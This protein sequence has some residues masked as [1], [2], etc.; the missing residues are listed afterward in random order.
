MKSNTLLLFFCL[1]LSSLTL[2]EEPLT[3]IA[4]DAF[5]RQIAPLLK[6][7]CFGC[8]GAEAQEGGVSY[9]EL[10]DENAL[11]QRPLWKRALARV[12]LG[13]M[14]PEGEE[15]LQPTEKKQL[16]AWMKQASVYLDCSPA[17]LDPGPAMIRRLN[18][19]E[20]D[21]TIRDLLGIRFNSAQAV[22]MPEEGAFEGFDN[23]AAALGFSPTLLEKYLAA[24]EKVIEELY[25]PQNRQALET[26]LGPLPSETLSESVAARQVTERLLSRAYRG[27]VE[28]A[29]LRPLAN[30]YKQARDSGETYEQ[31]VRKILK[32]ILVA[33]KFL[34]RFEMGQ[35]AQ[36][37]ARSVRVTDS[38]LAVRLSYFLWSSMPDDELFAV[39]ARGELS[40]PEVLQSQT[41]RMLQ[42]SRA[43]ALTENFAVQ[44]LQLEKLS[45]ARPTTE[46]FPT[47]THSL[48]NAMREETL[49][50]FDQLRTEDCSI[51]HLLDADYTFVNAELA[52]H[53]GVTG[54]GS[55]KLERVALR[56]ED[57]RGG[58]LGMGSVLAMTSHTFRT[59]PTQRGK[60]ILDVV[61][62]TPVPPPP[63]NV[64]PLQDD[65]NKARRT[66]VSFREQL[67]QHATEKACVGCHKKLDPLGF[68]LDNF[69]AVGAWRESTPE[70]P[71]DVQ[72]ELSSG[73]KFNGA[74]ELKQLLLSRK[75]DFAQ[76]LVARML[77]YSLGRELEYYD[78]CTIRE[79]SQ[80][81]AQQEYRFSE[82]VLGI[83]QSYPFQ[84]RRVGE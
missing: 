55:E 56:P 68:A 53:Y 20:Y 41:V 9:H 10:N 28:D 33:P 76:N 30:L 8:H 38:E 71:L 75:D 17:A 25:A 19:T 58:L 48:R 74:A 82:M 14:P 47:F 1:T 77:S 18:R 54:P 31:A 3:P 51:L 69:N 43:R 6:Q 2:G 57:H 52:K 4:A 7:H 32:P 39:A 60:Y 12:Q 78:D 26:L 15:P 61:L 70:S 42:D 40:R 11:R 65:N 29:D 49:T 80:R 24:A 27:P 16:V 50:F 5:S 13:E 59:S 36:P 67:A 44:W 34:Y 22:G 37:G 63:A 45:K 23:T 21:L 35:E 84:N 46:F 73:E 72:G 83:V 62:G 64:S 79:V 66:P 81:L